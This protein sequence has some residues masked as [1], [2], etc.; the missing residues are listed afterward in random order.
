MADV[1]AGPAPRQGESFHPKEDGRATHR[2]RDRLGWNRLSS[3][4]LVPGIDAGDAPSKR[5]DLRSDQSRRVDQSVGD[6]PA[7]T[8]GRAVDRGEQGVFEQ[9]Q[10]LL[11]VFG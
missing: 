7:G 10:Y 11:D 9:L 1:A 3:S 6:G 8:P 5:L 2:R 4:E